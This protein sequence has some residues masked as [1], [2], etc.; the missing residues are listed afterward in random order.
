[1]GGSIK[2]CEATG[3]TLAVFPSFESVMWLYTLIEEPANGKGDNVYHCFHI[4][5]YMDLWNVKK[6]PSV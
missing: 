5:V 6:K 1:M 3:D 4:Y 2:G